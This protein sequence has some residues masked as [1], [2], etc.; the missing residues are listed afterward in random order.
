MKLSE[1]EHYVIELAQKFSARSNV[2]LNDCVYSNL[3]I[4]GGD[5]VEFYAALE[6]HF[7]LDLRPVTEII[8]QTPSRWSGKSR[9]KAVAR[10]LPLK[11]I[12]SFVMAR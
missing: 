2:S 8:V 1:V 6:R 5:A 9:P 3:N 11:E 12:V 10:D 7:D 4:G